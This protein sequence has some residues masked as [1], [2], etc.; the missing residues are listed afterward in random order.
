VCASPQFDDYLVETTIARFGSTSGAA[1]SNPSCGAAALLT[2][3]IANATAA[4]FAVK[5]AGAVANSPGG[6]RLPYASAGIATSLP[7]AGARP[8]EAEEVDT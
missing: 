6:T 8:G 4:P 7:A 3:A 5:A 1:N 2:N